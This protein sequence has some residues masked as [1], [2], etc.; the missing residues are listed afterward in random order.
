MAKEQ[1]AEKLVFLI[2]WWKVS[3]SVT[4]SKW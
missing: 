4:V 1:K 2:D 3:E